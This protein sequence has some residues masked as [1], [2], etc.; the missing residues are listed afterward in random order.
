MGYNALNVANCLTILE[1]GILICP[2]IAKYIA[3]WMCPGVLCMYLFKSHFYVQVF[4]FV[5][6]VRCMFLTVKPF[7][8][9]A[10]W[11]VY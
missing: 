10:S 11:F 3:I 4:Y 7:N 2:F 6:L 5:R 1:V 8:T 9:K